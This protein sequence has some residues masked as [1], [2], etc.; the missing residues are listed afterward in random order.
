LKSSIAVA[1]AFLATLSGSEP[2]S[3]KTR[4]E[5]RAEYTAKEAAGATSGRSAAGYVKACR[6]SARISTAPEAKGPAREPEGHDADTDLAKKSENAIADLISVPFNNYATFNYGPNGHGRGTFDV[7]EIQ[8]V[9][10][11]HLTPDW[12]LI[13]RTILPVVW[14]PDLSPVPAVPVG[15][16]PTDF[17][18]FLPPKNETN[19]WLWGVGPVVQI[20]TR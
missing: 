8:P 3:A 6:A 12:N 5:C 10:P 9:I 2:A 1:L 20:P 19:G 18:A 11:I 13:T 14:T 4:A 17:S 15:V 7:L 16:A